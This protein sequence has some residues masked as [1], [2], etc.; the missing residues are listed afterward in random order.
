MTRP[1]FCTYPLNS[2][3]PPSK[4]KTHIAIQYPD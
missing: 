2:H 4:K 1:T 3:Q